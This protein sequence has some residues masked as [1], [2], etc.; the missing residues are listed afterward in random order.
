M[1]NVDGQISIDEFLESIGIHIG[2][3]HSCAAPAKKW[4]PVVYPDFEPN[5]E[6]TQY[7]LSCSFGKDSLACIGACQKL[8]WRID[9]I[10]HAEVWATDTI[11]AELPDMYNWKKE[12]MQLIEKNFGL[13]T[14]CYCAMKN[15][16]R[17]NYEKQ[18]YQK[19]K[20][21]NMKARIS[22]EGKKCHQKTTDYYGF[23]MSRGPWCNSKLKVAAIEEAQKMTYE[24]MFYSVRKSGARKGEIT[25]FPFPGH[26]EC[27]GALKRP[28]ITMAE[29]AAKT[30]GLKTVSLIGIAI[31]EP[32]RLERLDG[33]TKVSPLAAIG[34][35]E[36]DAM[37]WCKANNLRSPAYDNADRGGCW[38]CHNQGVDQLRKLRHNYP[39]LWQLLMKWDLDSSVTFHADGHTV[40]DFDKRFL[41][42]DKLLVPTD[43]RFRWKMLDNF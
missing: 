31:D 33:V 37:E 12:A 20:P 26:P 39:E 36:A 28:A 10:V 15:G 32:E 30:P 7:V 25:G 42:E 8:G 6:D 11:P 41:L 22:T 40:H 18:F 2:C 29:K 43:R 34:W 4:Q 38:F 24:K 5:R 1:N 17:N 21:E 13:K 27:N 16:E 23:P 14:E 19:I 35:T 9:R 3:Q